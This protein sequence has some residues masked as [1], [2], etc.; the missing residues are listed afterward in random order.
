M[1]PRINCANR[2]NRSLVG[3]TDESGTVKDSL[4]LI[5][6]L[7]TTSLYAN[8]EKL[9]SVIDRLFFRRLERRR[10]RLPRRWFAHGSTG[11]RVLRSKS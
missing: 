2:R 5:S 7:G 9:K 6:S 1:T 4:R 3:A 11:T 10:G 8:L